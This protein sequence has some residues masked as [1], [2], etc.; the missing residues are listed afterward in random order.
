MR[1]LAQSILFGF[2]VLIALGGLG[3]FVFTYLGVPAGGAPLLAGP[4][5]SY[6]GRWE[7]STTAL[8][9]AADG[10]VEYHTCPAGRGCHRFGGR[11]ASFDGDDFTVWVFPVF[12]S[13]FHVTSAPHAEG[14]ELRMVVDGNTLS[15]TRP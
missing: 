4:K 12:P 11:I 10:T 8:S 14:A 9:I 1:R 2:A 3:W 6:V 15:R 5:A 7:G 13:R